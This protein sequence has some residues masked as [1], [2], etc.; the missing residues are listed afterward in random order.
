MKRRFI[1]EADDDESFSNA[2]SSDTEAPKSTSDTEELSDDNK[3]KD[4]VEEPEEDSEQPEE[5]KQEELSDNDFTIKDPED[6]PEAE[7]STNSSGEEENTEEPS[8]DIDSPMKETERNLFDS[9][10]PEE[11]ELKNNMLKKLFVELY[12]NCDNIIEKI[13]NIGADF[14]EVNLQIKKMLTILFNLK[15]MIDDY[16]MNIYKG[17]TYIEND[18]MFN[19]YLSI[20]NSVKNILKDIDNYYENSK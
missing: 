17:K 4:T 11:Q 13:N 1:F 7:E 9:L 18:I 16:L 2:N 3:T 15:Q 20:L 14:D 6:E 8:E 12:S 5:E 10:S 19:R